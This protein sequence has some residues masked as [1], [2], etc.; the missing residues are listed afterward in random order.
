M[1]NTLFN[2]TMANQLGKGNSQLGK[3]H[4]GKV[5]INDVGFN[6]PLTFISTYYSTY[7]RSLNHSIDYN[8]TLTPLRIHVQRVDEEPLDIQE[9]LMY[10]TDY[11]FNKFFNDTLNLQSTLSVQSHLNRSFNESLTLNQNLLP[12]LLKT[13]SESISYN[14]SITTLHIHNA[15]IRHNLT[16]NSTFD[17]TIRSLWPHVSDRLHLTSL[18]FIDTPK[19]VLIAKS[20][21]IFGLPTPLKSIIENLRFRKTY[22]TMELQIFT[23]DVA[24]DQLKPFK[25]FLNYNRFDP[26][27]LSDTANTYLAYL[28]HSKSNR[29][30]LDMFNTSTTVTLTFHALLLN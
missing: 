15:S 18:V 2:T 17:T 30:A 14:Q 5:R 11:V 21:A 8:Q 16:Y 25:Q 24:P 9:I 13:I 23:F 12:V 7:N 28:H 1:I 10:D 20:G 6:D 26:F 27:A 22:K 3:I 4:A 19:F 29:E